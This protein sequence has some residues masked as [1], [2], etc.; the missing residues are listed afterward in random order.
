EDDEIA[1]VLYYLPETVV[2]LSGTVTTKS[3]VIDDEIV[4]TAV[5]KASLTT[6]PDL[7][8][9][10][11]AEIQRAKWADTS[12][13]IELTDDARLVSTTSQS[14]GKVGVIIK[15]LLGAVVGGIGFS[16]A[17]VEAQEKGPDPY[18]KWYEAVLK[19]YEKEIPTLGSRR[20]ELLD[21]IT[22]L[23]QAMSDL[24]N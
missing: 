23:S 1:P 16:L 24:Y 6:R 5:A 4:R 14:T 12:F 21:E 18:Q 9:P 11:E 15:N 8:R 3:N 17:G 7:E 22:R 2:E 10:C 19:L 13:A 20:K